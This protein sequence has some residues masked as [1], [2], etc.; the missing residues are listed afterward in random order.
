MIE[1]FVNTPQKPEKVVWYKKSFDKFAKGGKWQWSWWGFL[2]GP[3]FLLYRKVYGWGF[4][5][6][7]LTIAAAVIENHAVAASV[8]LILYVILGGFSAYLIYSRFVTKKRNIEEAFPDESQRVAEM[9]NIGGGNKAVMLA[10]VV[11]AGIVL[12]GIV[13]SVTIPKLPSFSP[14]ANVPKCSDPETIRL[15]KQIIGGNNVYAGLLGVNSL[16]DIKLDVIRTVKKD[17]DVNMYTCKANLNF[18]AD[19]TSNMFANALGK[20]TYTVSLT[21]D[22]K[23]FIVEL[24]PN[25]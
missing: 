22:K 9:Q 1:A 8:Q 12:L 2:M 19:T 10:P 16:E 15:V 3:W 7:V 25:Q 11:F 24:V 6:L 20:L 14:M 21:D 23:Q 5:F 17:P 13:A 18:G 4:L